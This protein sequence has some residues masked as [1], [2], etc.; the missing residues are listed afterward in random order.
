M[1]A[2]GGRILRGWGDSGPPVILS[3]V[4]TAVASDANGVAS[5]IPSVGGIPGEVEL[6][7]V[8]MAGTR[9]VAQFRL[10]VTTMGN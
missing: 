3:S 6:D 5:L 10:N 4:Q 7:I 9:G 1:P 8:A 2:R